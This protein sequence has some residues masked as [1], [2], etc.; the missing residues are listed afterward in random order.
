MDD[1]YL[2]EIPA[3]GARRRYGSS[4]KADLVRTDPDK[5]GIGT[6]RADMPAAGHAGRQGKDGNG[7]K[8]TDKEARRIYQA[9]SHRVA[10][11]LRP[12][13]V[14][15]IRTLLVDRASRCAPWGCLSVREP[16]LYSGADI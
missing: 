14:L 5:R 3:S 11:P 10:R 9:D 2:A 6:E 8:R 7:D 1:C 4:D 13:A 12:P 15:H 16:Y